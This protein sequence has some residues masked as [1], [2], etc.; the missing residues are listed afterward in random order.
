M[1]SNGGDTWTYS[2][3]WRL[4]ANEGEVREQDACRSTK[5]G[6]ETSGGRHGHSRER[7]R[8]VRN[9]ELK[10]VFKTK[11]VTLHTKKQNYYPGIRAYTLQCRPTVFS[12]VRG[13]QLVPLAHRA[14]EAEGA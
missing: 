7:D 11:I 9:L 1:A 10:Y 3:W 8:Y 12:T 2:N 5:R 13:L 14:D 6:T 4:P